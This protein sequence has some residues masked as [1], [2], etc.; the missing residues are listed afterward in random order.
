VATPHG[1]ITHDTL[2]HR[3]SSLP[4]KFVPPLKFRQGEFD[5][6]NL[7][8]DGATFTPWAAA[9]PQWLEAALSRFRCKADNYPGHGHRIRFMR[10]AVEGK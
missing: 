10:K 6:K 1:R 5:R 8:F 7:P 4:S 2:L 3:L 9:V